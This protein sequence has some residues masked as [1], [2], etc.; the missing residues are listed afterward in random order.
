[1]RIWGMVVIYRIS[2]NANVKCLNCI[3]SSIYLI[4]KYMNP[5]RTHQELRRRFIARRI[6]SQL[7][8]NLMCNLSSVNCQVMKCININVF[9]SSLSPAPFFGTSYTVFPPFFTASENTRCRSTIYA[10]SCAKR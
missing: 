10:F 6:F 7:P 9:I 4:A 5:L 3:I 8:S 2:E 1:M